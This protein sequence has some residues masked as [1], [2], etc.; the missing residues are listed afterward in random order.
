[1]EEEFYKWLI[2]FFKQKSHRINPKKTGVL[3]T[4]IQQTHKTPGLEV[5]WLRDLINTES[6]I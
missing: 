5:N 6:R 1:M 3:C 2:W 4:A